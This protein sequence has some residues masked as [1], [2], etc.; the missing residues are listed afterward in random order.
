MT[1]ER[2]VGGEYVCVCVWGGGG[3]GGGYSPEGPPRPRPKLHVD[4]GL[5][6][7]V[8]FEFFVA[9][10]LPRPHQILLAQPVLFGSARVFAD[11]AQLSRNNSTQHKQQPAPLPFSSE[12]TIFWVTN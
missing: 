3:G 11:L 10:V 5:H 1:R 7:Q 4:K 8:L 2:G 6:K 12:H 9:A